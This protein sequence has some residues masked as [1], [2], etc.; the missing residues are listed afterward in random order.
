MTVACLLVIAVLAA[1][2]KHD[3]SQVPPAPA[4]HQSATGPIGRASSS[5]SAKPS[6][7]ASAAPSATAASP[8]PSVNPSAVPANSGSGARIVYSISAQK[9]WIVGSNNQAERS[10]AIVP[11]T[12]APPTGSYQVNDKLASEVGSDG[13]PVQYVVLF[14]DVPVDGTST[15]FGFDTVAGVTG[16]P[17]PPSTRTG[18]IRMAAD[19]A[20]AIWQFSSVGT[21]VVVVT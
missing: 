16:M 20:E 18:G 13:T 5:A 19:D 3:N 7:T 1:K 12:V 4:A 14:A 8:S 11:G 6:T 10:F 9:V 15:V 21:S 17:S 2:A